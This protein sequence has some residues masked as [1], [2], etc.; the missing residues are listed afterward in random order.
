MGGTLG[1]MAARTAALSNYMGCTLSPEEI[2]DDFKSFYFETALS[3]YGPA[4]TAIDEFAQPGHLL[5]GSDFP[6]QLSGYYLTRAFDVGADEFM[7]SSTAVS[8]ESVAWFSKR[9]DEHYRE[10]GYRLTGVLYK[11][12]L[13]LFK[14]RGAMTEIAPQA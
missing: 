10:D 9:L 12:A 6:G 14:K 5:Y 2:L 4:L 3:A 11:N 8:S 13:Q 7:V 1:S